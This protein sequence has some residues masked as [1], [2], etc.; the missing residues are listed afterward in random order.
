MVIL[1]FLLLVLKSQ[2]ATLR[3]TCPK[4]VQT[5]ERHLV[6]IVSPLS[7]YFRLPNAAAR[8]INFLVWQLSKFLLDL[9]GSASSPTKGEMKYLL[10]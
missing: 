4:G 3:G 9:G 6:D 5:D 1:T 2:P 7:R 10:G 8:R